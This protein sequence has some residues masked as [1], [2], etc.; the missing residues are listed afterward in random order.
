MGAPTALEQYLVELVNAERA[1]RGL[2]PLAYDSKLDNAAAGHTAWMMNTGGFSHTGAGGSSAHKRVAA[3]GYDFVGGGGSAENIA[4]ASLR[5]AEGLQDDVELMHQSWM[6]S[7]G[8]RANILNGQ[9]SEI[10]VGLAAGAYSRFSY[11]DSL[12]GTQN[13]ANARGDN[14]FV[15]GVVIDDR[16]IDRFYDVGEG[17]G[18]ITVTARAANGATTQTVTNDAGGYS[19]ALASGNYTLTFE[20]P[21]FTT[22]VRDVSIGDRNVKVDVYAAEQQTSSPTPPTEPAA[23][24][25]EGPDTNPPEPES[26]G[27]DALNYIASHADLIAAFRGFDVGALIEIAIAH[28]ELAGFAEG[29][30]AEGT[31]QFDPKQYIENY[32]D[33][34]GMNAVDAALH[35]IEFGAEEG[36]LAFDAMAYIASHADLIAAFGADEGS[37]VAHY[38]ASGREEGRGVDFD[39]AQYLENYADL[40]A[41]LGED[42]DVAAGHFVTNGHDEGRTDIDPLDYLASHADLRGA[43]GADT[44]A[45]LLHYVAFGRVE[46]RGVDFD[47]WQYLQNYGDLQQ[48]FG[49]DEDAAALH[50]ITGGYEEGRTD[51]LVM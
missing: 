42:E 40:R 12:I 37:G 17:L 39:G 31:P 10:G 41:A 7:S 13:F 8:H 28:Y 9:M 51:E 27:N 20:R 32:A 5:G 18:G 15:T 6:N 23:P 26:A 49:M 21:G 1:E 38:H 30:M 46:G 16:D 33:L 22:Q 11:G 44:D 4:W 25:P 19:L 50:F 36:R 43:F 24:P 34:A 35:F 45:A 29:R 2:Q 47:A 48:A 3:A 14:P